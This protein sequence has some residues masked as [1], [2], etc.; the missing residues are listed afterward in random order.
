MSKV[1]II[2]PAKPR[3][4][5]R[6]RS[7]RHYLAWIED[8]IRAVEAGAIGSAEGMRRGAM[9]QIAAQ[10]FL[11]AT[12]LEMRGIGKAIDVQPEED[13]VKP[14]VR[15]PH[16]TKKVTAK[17]GTGKHGEVIDERTV[18]ITSSADDP[19]LEVDAEIEA[20]T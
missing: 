20:L 1:E 6:M 5:A 4:G 11:T 15:A 7:A 9:Q 8:T 3:S 18:S 16:R 14:E 2:P 12:E 13:Y 19:D 10:V 17:R